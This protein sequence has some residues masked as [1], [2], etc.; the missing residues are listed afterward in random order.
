MWVSST[1][2]STVN[3]YPTLQLLFFELSSAFSSLD[4]VV[5]F[6]QLSPNPYINHGQLF[7]LHEAA[8]AK[9]MLPTHSERDGEPKSQIDFWRKLNM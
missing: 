9:C 6:Q 2:S 4:R 5:E 8:Q 7:P 3:E 1:V